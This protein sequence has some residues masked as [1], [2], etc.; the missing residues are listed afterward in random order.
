MQC[1]RAPACPS[2]VRAHHKPLGAGA[3]SACGETPEFDCIAE[4]DSLAKYVG[5]LTKDQYGHK[6]ENFDALEQ[7][8]GIP[9]EHRATQPT[10][11]HVFSRLLNFC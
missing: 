5:E 6:A 2:R 3:Q 7:A 10:I 11:C 4:S 1:Q 8:S 9:I